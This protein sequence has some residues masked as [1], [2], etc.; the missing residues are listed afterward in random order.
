M[1]LQKYEARIEESF[2]NGSSPYTATDDERVQQVPEK[3]GQKVCVDVELRASDRLCIIVFVDGFFPKKRSDEMEHYHDVTSPIST[4][5]RPEAILSL[6]TGTV[7]RPSSD[8]IY[9][10]MVSKLQR[11]S[12]VCSRPIH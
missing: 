3:V 7:T 12:Q 4:A 2:N 9:R 1:T 8:D 5:P 10:T 6:V 11:I